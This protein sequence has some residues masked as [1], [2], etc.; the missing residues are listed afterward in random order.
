MEYP[1]ICPK[2][3]P[4]RYIYEYSALHKAK[5]LLNNAFKSELSSHDKLL[6]SP[7]SFF[8]TFSL[9][10][11]SVIRFTE[12]TAIYFSTIE[13]YRVWIQLAKCV[14]YAVK[15]WGKVVCITKSTL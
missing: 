14:K 13:A 1:C 12:G 4:N 15:K 9:T 5:D 3:L 2:P 6:Y 8:K 11:D 10:D 7:V